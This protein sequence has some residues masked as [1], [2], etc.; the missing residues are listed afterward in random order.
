MIFY[1]SLRLVLCS[2]HPIKPRLGVGQGEVLFPWT[3]SVFPIPS[4]VLEAIH[5]DILSNVYKSTVKKF[6]RYRRE[7]SEA[8]SNLSKARQPSASG[9]F[10]PRP[11]GQ[12]TA[13]NLHCFLGQS[14]ILIFIQIKS[15]PNFLCLQSE[16][17]VT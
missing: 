12:T 3:S 13:L 14:C 6:C 11:S 8:L 2:N 5:C 1:L 10:E 4:S 9:G 15:V 16:A 7:L 17:S